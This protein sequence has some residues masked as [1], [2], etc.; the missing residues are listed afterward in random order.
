M[1]IIRKLTVLTV[2]LLGFQVIIRG[3]D[4]LSFSDPPSLTSSQYYTLTNVLAVN[5]LAESL[6]DNT[7]RIWVNPCRGKARELRLSFFQFD[8]E[9]SHFIL[10]VPNL[11]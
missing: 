5:C 2:L 1:K 10:H 3:S 6:I 11:G 7:G 4:N 8:G 9:Q